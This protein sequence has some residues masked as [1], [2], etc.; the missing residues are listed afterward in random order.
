MN[1]D[2][3]CQFLIR[4]DPCQ[5]VVKFLIGLTAAETGAFLTMNTDQNCHFF[6]REDPCQSVVKFLV[7]YAA[8]LL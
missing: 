1:T 5:S 7:G 3:N 2:R 4:E 6:I 8:L